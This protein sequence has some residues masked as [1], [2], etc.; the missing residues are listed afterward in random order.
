VYINKNGK[1][2]NSVG[3]SKN[4]I[5]TIPAPPPYFFDGSISSRGALTQKF[6]D[7]MVIALTSSI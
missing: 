6:I 1:S 7:K 5:K 4:S 2:K 3:L